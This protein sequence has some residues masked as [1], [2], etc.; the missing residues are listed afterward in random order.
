MEFGEAVYIPNLSKYHS[1][2]D[3][4]DIRNGHDDRIVKLHDLRLNLIDL[5]I[6]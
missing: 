2:V 1:A 4:P 3:V 6:Q 5:A